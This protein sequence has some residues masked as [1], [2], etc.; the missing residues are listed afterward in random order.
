MRTPRR[1]QRLGVAA[2]ALMLTVGT[3]SACQ[4]SSRA[5]QEDREHFTDEAPNGDGRNTDERAE[6]VIVIVGDGMVVAQRELIRRTA[7]GEQGQLAMDQLQYQGWT[8]TDPADPERAITD[9]AAAATALATGVRAET[10]AVAVDPQGI[11]L[12][13]LLEQ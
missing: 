3:A 13:T 9:S 11:R 5:L 8:R 1:G 7:G 2:L 6:N 10:G 4:S 12:P